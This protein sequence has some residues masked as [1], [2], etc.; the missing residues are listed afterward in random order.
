MRHLSLLVGLCV[1][2]QDYVKTPKWISMKLSGRIGRGPRKNP[3]SFS[4]I[5][6][7]FRHICGTDIFECVS[8]G[9]INL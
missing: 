7:L 6:D 1:Q 8:A 2:Q 3:F 4:E 5:P 9:I